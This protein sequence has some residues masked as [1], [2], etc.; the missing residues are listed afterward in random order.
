MPNLQSGDRAG[1]Q[2]SPLAEEAWTMTR[3]RTDAEGAGCRRTLK[4]ATELERKARAYRT[5]KRIAVGGGCAAAKPPVNPSLG[6]DIEAS[7]HATLLRATLGL[8]KARASNMLLD[9]SL[10]E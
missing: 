1:R 10:A 7:G 4:K 6:L 3:V 5:G 9:Q 8:S 2:R